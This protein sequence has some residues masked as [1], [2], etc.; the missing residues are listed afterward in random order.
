MALEYL[1]E[2]KLSCLVLNEESEVRTAQRA[3]QEYLGHESVLTTLLRD[4]AVDATKIYRGDNTVSPVVLWDGNAEATTMALKNMYNGIAG[5]RANGVD[6]P[7][8]P[9]YGDRVQ[10]A[11]ILRLPNP[12][13]S[14]PL[15]AAI[16]VPRQPVRRAT[17]GIL[18]GQDTETMRPLR[19]TGLLARIALGLLHR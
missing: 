7:K 19:I 6:T 2:L 16:P 8:W 18:E 9:L 3:V 11:A 13:E 4:A 15:I 17:E 14:S 1:P 12:V 10:A 5:P